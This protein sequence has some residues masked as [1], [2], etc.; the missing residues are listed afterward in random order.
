MT[1]KIN[2]S[3]NALTGQL[4][5]VNG[6][7]DFT[8]S[9]PTCTAGVVQGNPLIQADCEYNTI[10]DPQNPYVVIELICPPGQIALQQGCASTGPQA[11]TATI[12]QAD[13]A[14]CYYNAPV[15]I[16]AGGWTGTVSATCVDMTITAANGAKLVATVPR[17]SAGAS[18]AKLA[19]SFKN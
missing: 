18:R 12:Q 8:T 13:T 14:Q 3:P 5:A 10:D 4:T 6:Q 17:V 19:A 1:Q 15:G 16:P 11:L 9:P 2:N 7:L